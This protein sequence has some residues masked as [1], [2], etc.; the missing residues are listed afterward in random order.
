MVYKVLFSSFAKWETSI[1]F[2][3]SV[4][5][6][7]YGISRFI[8]PWL[9][10]NTLKFTLINQFVVEVFF[11][12]VYLFNLFFQMLTVNLTFSM[13]MWFTSP[14]ELDRQTI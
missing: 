8:D 3:S 6:K 9:T 10:L 14:P 13:W 7:I 11:A 12:E 4:R 1:K 2:L 5:C